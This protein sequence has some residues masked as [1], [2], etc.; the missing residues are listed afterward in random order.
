MASGPWIES[1]EIEALVA[2]MSS[3][4]PRGIIPA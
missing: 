1:N 3:W 4:G 2:D